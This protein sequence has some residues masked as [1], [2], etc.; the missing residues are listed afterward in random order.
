[1]E[2]SDDD[3]MEDE[4]DYYGKFQNLNYFQGFS[5]SLIKFN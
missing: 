4:M 3:D 2:Y 5:T 1:M